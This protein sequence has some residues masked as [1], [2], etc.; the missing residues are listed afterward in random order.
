MKVR[1]SPHGLSGFVTAP[2]SKSEAHRLLICAALSNAPVKIFMG[3]DGSEGLPDDIKATVNCLAALGTQ[4]A[5][6]ESGV[7]N[8]TPLNT[9]NI[10]K[11][12]ELDCHESGSTLR[13]ILPVACA[14]CDS[15]SV[16]AHGRLPERPLSELMSAME[17]HGVKF[18]SQHLPFETSG[19]LQSGTYELPGNVSSQYISGLMLAL[20][21]LRNDSTIK[22]TSLLKSAAYVDITLSALKKFGV[23]VNTSGNTYRIPGGKKFSSPH[24][25][26]ADGD[27]SGAAFFLAA[28]ALSGPVS[29]K[30]LSMN[31][32]QGDKKIVDILRKLGACVKVYD[33]VITVSPISHAVKSYRRVEIDIDPTPD[34]LPV[35]AITAS[36]SGRDVKFYNASRLRLKES[37]RIKS[38]ASIIRSLGGFATENGD[39]LF[40]NGSANLTG[41]LAKGFHDHRI[42][43][44]A[45]VAG[46]KCEHEVIITDAE[47]A[48]KSYPEFF[49]D[50]E[51]L[52]GHVNVI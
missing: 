48:G 36:C 6:D 4:I 13:F 2:V 22:L 14:L 28:G 40:V 33:D 32:P 8:V 49:K 3:N 18:S 21:V 43:M 45:A 46:V 31:S 37:D 20:P 34:L 11:H 29:V 5:F 47:S 23:E 30:G 41:G 51:S 10:P 35:L 7:V 27:W 17:I 19:K 24:E 1:I 9:N 15:V 50:Y 39:E 42:V 16:R 52:G 12:A 25:I 44:A 38:T 26:S